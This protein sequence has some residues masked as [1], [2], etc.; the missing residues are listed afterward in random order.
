MSGFDWHNLKDDS[1]S[2]HISQYGSPKKSTIAFNDFFAKEIASSE[3]VIDIAG[4]A[5]G[6]VIYLAQRYPEIQFTVFDISGELI[7][8]GEK[9]IFNLGLK[10]VDF[11][12]GDVI[13]YDFV[14]SYDCV[15]C[16]QTLS[17]LES[18]QEFL[19]SILRKLNPKYLGITSLFYEGEISAKIN[20]TEHQINRMSYYNVYSMPELERFL[21]E[22]GYDELEYVPFEIDID[23]PKPRENDRMSTY[24]LPLEQG[25]VQKKIQVSGPVMMPWY[26]V[27]T[28]RS[29]RGVCL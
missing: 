19:G 10:N 5:G 12:L 7:A 4:G 29:D 15:I 17:W 8:I 18:Y 21:S 23:I 20:V 13:T 16:T 28:S 24:T 6:V 14:D 26:L 9:Q 1:V 27:K 2:Y 11:L 22:Y 25:F 3:R